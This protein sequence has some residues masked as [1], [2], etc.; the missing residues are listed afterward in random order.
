MNELMMDLTRSSMNYYSC[1]IIMFFFLRKFNYDDTFHA[2][3]L[4]ANLS[5]ILLVFLNSIVL[6]CTII[7]LITTITMILKKKRVRYLMNA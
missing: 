3:Y 4:L 2:V 6:T 5:V 1:A 7:L